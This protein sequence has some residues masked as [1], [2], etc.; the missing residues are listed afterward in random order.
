MPLLSE[1]SADPRSLLAY[2]NAVGGSEVKT[3]L[4][5]ALADLSERERG[6]LAMRFGLKDGISHR[7]DIIAEVYGI[8]SERVRQIEAKA[9]RRLRNP[10]RGRGL[11]QIVD[12]DGSKD[13]FN[14]TM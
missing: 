9:V 13:A 5:A 7:L 4:F 11:A 8:T 2:K 3:R 1:T 14:V 12:A 10:R 6:V